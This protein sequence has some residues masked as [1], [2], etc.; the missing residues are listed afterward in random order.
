[1]IEKEFYKLTAVSPCLWFYLSKKWGRGN[2]WG[3]IEPV[4]LFRHAYLRGPHGDEAPP[5]D[6]PFCPP[7]VG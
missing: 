6:D 7:N 4:T 5:A 3:V 1:M 2:K